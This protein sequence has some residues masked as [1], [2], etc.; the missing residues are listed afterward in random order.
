MGHMIEKKLAAHGIEL[1]QASEDICATQPSVAKECICIDFTTPAAFRANYKFI[2]AN[3]KAAVIGTT[4]WNDIQDEVI[5]EFEKQGTPM[6]YAS[7]FSIGVNALFAAVEKTA[8]VLK[9]H[10]YEPHI[11][12]THHIHKLDAPSGTAKSLGAL[13]AAELG[14]EPKIDS[15]HTHGG[16]HIQ[17][18]PPQLHPRS[19]FS[20]RARR[21]SHRRSPIDRRSERSTRI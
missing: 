21:R 12:E 15:R 5:A 7:N 18:R 2:A 19:F 17:R 1:V 16:I 20:R 10:G 4:G 8:K 9:G 14:K 11:T 13:V 6:I 3:F